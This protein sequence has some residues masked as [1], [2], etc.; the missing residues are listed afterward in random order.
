MTNLRPDNNFSKLPYEAQAFFK[1]GLIRAV[2]KDSGT[3]ALLND[4]L[5][6]HLTIGDNSSTH[7]LSSQLGSGSS[8]QDLLG[9]FNFFFNLRQI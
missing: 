3:I 4:A 1:S 5:T 2:F 8:S 6:I 9:A 7:S